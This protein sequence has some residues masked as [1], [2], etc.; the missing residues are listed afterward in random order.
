MENVPVDR[1]FA[2]Y[3]VSS[4][5]TMFLQ[6]AYS[7]ID[8]L[9]VSNLISETALAAI[10]VAWPIIAV[11]TAMGTGI[12]CGGA[13]IMSTKQGEGKD[14]ES[15]IARANVL[16]AL[17][18]ASVICTVVFLSL[19][20][21]LL[22]MMGAT[23]EL[24]RLSRIYVR[25]MV[26]G[27]A[28]QIFSCG[29]TPLLRNDNKTVSAMLIMVS[30]LLINLGM[31]YL[32]MAVFGRG[33]EAAAIA[34]LCAQ[35]FTT[36]SCLTL[37]IR[38]KSNPLRLDQFTMRAEY[39]KRIFKTAVSPFGI[40][41]TPSLL[42][43]YH[44]VACLGTGDDLAISA[45]ALISS[46]VGSYRILLIGVAEGMQPL[47]SFANGARD[48]AAMRRIR[49]KAIGTAVTVSVLLFLLAIATARYYPALYG[50]SDEAARIGVHAVLVTAPQ[51]IFTGLVRVTNSFFYAVGKDR[52]SL[53]MIYFDPLIMTP[54][55]IHLLPRLLGLDGI[56][57]TAVVTQFALNVAA[58]WM[59][60]RHEKEIK[61]AE[62]RIRL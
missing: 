32:L 26:A 39:W 50:Y 11:V 46:T 25:I 60:L 38:K 15:N 23:G 13:V 17:L 54:V 43:L 55:V 49:N 12:G 9:F 6:S 57:L 7:M 58:V 34:S 24:L 29:L 40:S 37:L 10:N 45:Y 33:I 35:G 59:F 31:D 42:I 3:V 16:A 53:F 18:A 56:W 61:I 41:L 21:P 48:F 44:N 1:K 47:A 2:K 30:G 36:V 14:E 27:G 19:I 51:L 5:V 52:Y 20:T 28:L 4:M 22:T 8:G 62:S